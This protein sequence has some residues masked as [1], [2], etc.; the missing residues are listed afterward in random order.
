MDDDL[1]PGIIRQWKPVDHAELLACWK[2]LMPE[3]NASLQPRRFLGR[4]LNPQQA[5]WVF[6]HWVCE[7]FRLVGLRQTGSEDHSSSIRIQASGPRRRRT[8]W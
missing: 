1:I 5:G 4:D 2:G 6:E 3:L 7:A 8:E